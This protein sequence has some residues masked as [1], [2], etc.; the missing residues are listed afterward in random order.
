[1]DGNSFFS[2]A[3]CAF[4]T[5]MSH[6]S[7]ASLH[8]KISAGRAGCQ[9]KSKRSKGGT[10]ARNSVWIRKQIEQRCPIFQGIRG[11]R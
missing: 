11:S 9:L 1:M 10:G 8:F 6:F 5:V 2:L 4:P 7:R 3:H